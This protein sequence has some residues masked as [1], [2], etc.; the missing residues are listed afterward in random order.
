MPTGLRAAPSNDN[1]TADTYVSFDILI[2][3][4]PIDDRTVDFSGLRRFAAAG[5]KLP[6]KTCRALLR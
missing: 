3:I 6:G 4:N 2:I 1:P 5:G